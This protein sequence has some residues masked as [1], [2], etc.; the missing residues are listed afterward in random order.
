MPKDQTPPSRPPMATSEPPPPLAE[1]VPSDGKVH[2]LPP[3][4]SPPGTSG[5]VV[6][7]PVIK[8]TGEILPN[9]VSPAVVIDNAHDLP[10]GPASLGPIRHRDPAK[11]AAQ[12]ELDR[13]IQLGPDSP[14]YDANRV[15]ELHYKVAGVEIPT[16]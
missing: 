1:P 6:G 2:D 11:Q 10:K 3:A 4:T 8:T 5:K 12:D 16:R 9:V 14:E 7:L 13:L 15:H